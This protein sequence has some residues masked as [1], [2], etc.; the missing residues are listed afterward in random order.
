MPMT[1][2]VRPSIDSLHCDAIHTGS[3]WVDWSDL[4]AASEGGEPYTAWGAVQCESCGAVVVLTAGQGG[5]VHRHFGDTSCNGYVPTF[6]G[7]AM[8]YCYPLPR[9]VEP[10]DAA[11]QIAHLPLCLIEWGDGSG[12]GGFALAL[13]GG[14]MD[15][16]WDI[17]E[18]FMCLGELPPVKY[19]G[20]LPDQGEYGARARYVLAGARKS[21]RVAGN[22]L[23]NQRRHL[24][25]IA[26]RVRET[27]ARRKAGASC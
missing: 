25:H 22:W 4:N 10:L 8:N 2:I 13:T 6:E 20:D 3:V 1:K 17:C 26:A 24:K 5:E 23:A 15:L 27:D 18:A 19:A 9:N 7:P 11:K 14:G 12:H 21:V 16:S